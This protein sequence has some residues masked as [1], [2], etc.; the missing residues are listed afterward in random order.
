VAGNRIVGIHQPE[1]L[2]WMGLLNKLA[3][4]DTF[5]LL[6]NVQ[7]R[8]NYFQN[9]NRIRTSEG[10]TWLTVPVKKAPLETVISE[11]QVDDSKP[12]GES[13]WKSL[14]QNYSKARHFGEY[15]E[16]FKEIYSRN[17]ARLVELNTEIIR[18]FADALGIKC[19]IVLASQL[20]ATGTSTEL[21]LRICEE[22]DADTY[23]SGRF[24]K[25]YLDEEVFRGAGIRVAYQDFQHPEYEQVYQPFVPAMAGVDLLFNTGT[26]GIE[27]IRRSWVLTDRA[28]Y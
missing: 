27:Y 17:W 20:H 2:P 6:D 22:L 11:I 23:L 18:F 26:E 10:W 5:V 14:R 19:E 21:L 12:W 4:S 3:N 25:D 8:R 16:F 15:S 28:P 13:H 1:Y 9:R 7:Y 24:G